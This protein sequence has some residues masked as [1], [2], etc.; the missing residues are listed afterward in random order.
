MIEVTPRAHRRAG[1]P[2]AGGVG[3]PGG[4]GDRGRPEC[5]EL[6]KAGRREA[7]GR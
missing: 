5:V 6:A 1:R 7:K 3:V 4:V 2:P